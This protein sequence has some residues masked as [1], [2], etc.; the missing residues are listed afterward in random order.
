MVT[1]VILLNVERSQIKAVGEALAAFPE[2]ASVY[3]V[4]GKFD[5]VATVRVQRNDDLAELVTERMVA[6][7]GILHTET[8]IAFRAYSRADIESGF[9]LG[10]G[11]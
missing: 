2:A 4:A 10:A 11:S 8:L 9:S 6:L 7:P 5:L 3:S 1:A